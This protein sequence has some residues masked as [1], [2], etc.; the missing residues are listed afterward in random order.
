MHLLSI[1]LILLILSVWMF[2]GVSSLYSVKKE[3][4][5]KRWL[6]GLAAILVIVGPPWFLWCRPLRIWRIELVAGIV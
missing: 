1:I 3:T 4:G 2:F 5:A 6:I